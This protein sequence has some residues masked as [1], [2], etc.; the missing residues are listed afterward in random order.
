MIVEDCAHAFG[1]EYNGKKLSNHGN[2]CVY[3][4][5]YKTFNHW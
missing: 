2:I 5:G 1:A 4:T 3:N